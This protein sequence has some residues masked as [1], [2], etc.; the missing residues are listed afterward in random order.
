MQWRI[1]VEGEACR[2]LIFAHLTLG[3]RE[4]DH[5]S[6][7]E[8]D[9]ERKRFSFRPDPNWL[10]GQRYPDA[11]YHLVTST[12]DAIEAIGG[13]E[14][15][16]AD[17]IFRA[18]AYVALRTAPT[19]TFCFA[20]VGSLTDAAAADALATK[21]ERGVAD[22]ELSRPR[23]ASGGRSRAGCASTAKANS[24]SLFPWLA[25]NAM[26]HLTAPHGLE[27]YTGAAWGT[28]DV[29]QGPVEF[30]LA[31]EHD[32]AVK[33]ILRLVF[34]QQYESSG[35]WPQW[36]MLD[37]YADHSG[38]GQPWRR[39]RLAAEGAERLRRGDRRLRFPRR[40]GGVARGQSGAHR[41]RG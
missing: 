22:E 3:E 16:Y 8:V 41:T 6:R 12:P 39:H 18:G 5:A 28:R 38:Q 23:G 21:F 25:Q 10:W 20:V 36:F 9:A 27:Q 37:P 24:I 31:L 32:D 11:V 34:A 15:L 4:L 14:L 19:D 26:I 1:A 35:D 29:C 40:A 2:F 30:L 13:D 17:G 33:A 7:I